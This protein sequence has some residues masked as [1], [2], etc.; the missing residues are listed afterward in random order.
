MAKRTQKVITKFGQKYL[1]TY[2][3]G[4]L[5]STTRMQS[6]KEA[7]KRS[8]ARK[9]YQKNTKTTQKSTTKT[10]A[11]KSTPAKPVTTNK[12]TDRITAGKNKR[13]PL[14]SQT[15]EERTGKVD[16]SKDPRK[17]PKPSTAGKTIKYN[18]YN[19]KY[20]YKGNLKSVTKSS[21]NDMTDRERS[22]RE[23][24]KQIG[25]YTKN[26]DE[27]DLAYKI[28]S[29]KYSDD[30]VRK[31]NENQNNRL[32]GI[33]LKKINDAINVIEANKHKLDGRYVSGAEY[34]KIKKS[35]DEA[36]KVMNDF[37]DFIDIYDRGKKSSLAA[38][39]QSAKD[40]IDSAEEMFKKNN[41]FTDMFKTRHEYY[42]VQEYSK[43]EYKNY[44]RWV[45]KRN[46]LTAEQKQLLAI[47]ENKRT[48]DQKLRL[49]E[50][51][52]AFDIMDKMMVSDPDLIK[53]MTPSQ[54]K[55]YSKTLEKTRKESEKRLATYQQG[56]RQYESEKKRLNTLKG[57]EDVYGYTKYG[58][59]YQDLERS[60][61]NLVEQFRKARSES[62]R[63]AIRAEISKISSYM[64]SEEITSGMTKEEFD[65]EQKFFEELYYEILPPSGSNISYTPEGYMYVDSE[66]GRKA[67][68]DYETLKGMTSDFSKAR[69]EF[70]AQK[71][72]SEYLDKI[73]Y[74][75]DTDVKYSRFTNDATTVNAGVDRKSQR[76][77]VYDVI[78]YGTDIRYGSQERGFDF[79]ILSKL[80]PEERRVYNFIVNK[81]GLDAGFEFI[82]E[83]TPALN[84]RYTESKQIEAYEYGNE[85]PVISLATRGLMAVP[86]ALYDLYGTASDVMNRIAGNDIDIYDRTHL[87][88]NTLSAERQGATESIKNPF[89]QFFYSAADSALNEAVI[90]A[91]TYGLGKA[92]QLGSKGMSAINMVA[93]SGSAFEGK[94]MEYKKAGKS[95]TNAILAGFA[96]AGIEAMTERMPL[97]NIFKAPD[98]LKNVDSKKVWQIM[99][100]AGVSGMEEG[101]EELASYMMGEMY[102]I[103]TNASDMTT[104]YQTYNK[105][106]EDGATK[107]EA[108]ADAF[109]E[110][111]GEAGKNLISGMI[112]GSAL[113]VGSSASNVM[114][115]DNVRKYAEDRFYVDGVTPVTVGATLMDKGNLSSR[116]AA[117]WA[118]HIMDYANGKS[119]SNDV[120]EQI[121][122]NPVLRGVTFA[123]VSANKDSR[124]VKEVKP[125]TVQQT[126][127]VAEPEKESPV[128]QSPVQSKPVDVVPEK[129]IQ[130]TPTEAT[131]QHKAEPKVQEQPKAQ[132]EVKQNTPQPKQTKP[133]QPKPQKMES[134]AD[135]TKVKTSVTGNDG[136]R[137]TDIIN[138]IGSDSIARN[139]KADRP[140]I[141]SANPAGS[142]IEMD[143]PLGVVYVPG[144]NGKTTY[145]AYYSQTQDSRGGQI[146]SV[147]SVDGNVA[148]DAIY[149]M[150]FVD[151][152]G[153]MD[154]VKG[155]GDSRKSKIPKI[156]F[157][158][159]PEIVKQLVNQ[160]FESATPSGIRGQIT[161]T[162]DDIDINN[163]ND[164]SISLFSEVSKYL[165]Q[166]IKNK[167]S[168]SSQM[169]GKAPR[170]IKFGGI[171]GGGNVGRAMNIDEIESASGKYIEVINE[172]MSMDEA[173]RDQILSEITQIP[174]SVEELYSILNA[175]EEVETEAIEPSDEHVS[176]IKYNTEP[177]DEVENVKA[178]ESEVS[179][180]VSEVEGELSNIENRSEE[181]VRD[182]KSEEDEGD[183]SDS[184]DLESDDLE[185]LETADLIM[186]TDTSSVL[187]TMGRNGGRAYSFAIDR[188]L[189]INTLK[190]KG[191]SDAEAREKFNQAFAFMYEA[192][193]RGYDLNKSLKAV[194]L[195][196]A[197]GI[198][199]HAR[200]FFEAGKKDAAQMFRGKTNA[201]LINNFVL[202]NMRA[203][204]E[205]SAR[206]IRALNTLA[207][208]L[209][210]DI[211]FAQK[212]TDKDGNVIDANGKFDAQNH[213]ITINSSSELPFFTVAVHETIHAIRN[214]DTRAYNRIARVVIDVIKSGHPAAMEVLN[215]YAGKHGKDI[216]SGKI[217]MSDINEEIVCHITSSLLTDESFVKELARKNRNLVQRIYDYIIDYIQRKCNELWLTGITPATKNAV[218]MLD[219]DFTKIKSL[220]ETALKS[221]QN[222][223]TDKGKASEVGGEMYAKS[224]VYDYTKSFAEQLDDFDNIPE[225]DSLLVGKTPDVFTKIGFNPLPVTINRTHV[226]YALN[227]TKDID[228]HL[229]IKLLKQLPQALKKP[230][231]IIH[232]QTKQN[233]VVAILK[234]VHNGKN[235]VLPIEIDGF[236]TQNNLRLDSNAIT[237]ILGKTNAIS[238]QLTDALMNEA[239][240]NI[241]VFYWNK[242]EALS[243][244][245]RPGHQLPNRLPQD[246]FVHSI[247]ENGSPVNKRFDNVTYSQQFIRWFGNWIKNPKKASKV[248]NSDGTPKVM[249][250]GG[251]ED[252]RIFDRKKSRASN[253]YGRGFYF[254]DSEA[255]AKQYGDAREYYLN[256]KT[257]LKPNEHNIS[258]EQ[259]RK[260]LEAIAE[261]EDD[262]DI[263]N[264]G[265]TDIDEILNTVYGK[266]DFEVLQDINATAIGDL[267]EAI[268]LF[269]KINNTSYDGI[270][271]PTETVVFRSNQIK[272]VENV[273]TFDEGNDDV[274]Y[275]KF[276]TPEQFHIDDRTF[277]NVGSKSVKAFQFLHPEVKAYYEPIVRELKNDLQN[278]TK[279]ERI[280]LS[281]SE[282]GDYGSNPLWMGTKRFT[283]EAIARI[284]D[285]TGA[286]YDAI[287][288]ALNALLEGDGAENNALSKRIELVIDEMLTDGYTDFEG[289]KIPADKDYVAAKEVL[290]T[291]VSS[292]ALDEAIMNSPD[293]ISTE[294]L[295]AIKSASVKLKE[296]VRQ[297]INKYVEKYGELEKGSRPARDVT[298]PKKT[299]EN[300]YV[301]RNTRTIAEAEAITDENA[302]VLIEEVAND[303]EWTTYERFGDKQAIDAAV[304]EFERIG[305]DAALAKWRAVYDSGKR[306]TK[307]DIADGHLLIKE[308]A[309]RGDTKTFVE[310]ASKVAEMGTMSGQVVQAMFLI[311]RM[312]PAVQI[313]ALESNI[314][315][316]EE[317]INKKH[318]WNDFKFDVPQ[319]LIE[320]YTEAL[321]EEER[322]EKQA[323]KEGREIDKA[324]KKKSDKILERIY[325]HMSR[326]VPKTWVDRITTWRYFA[327]LGNPRTH[328]RNIAGNAVFMP[329]VMTKHIVAA[330][331]ED[332]VG[333]I[334]SVAG[335]NMERTK[336]IRG[337][338]TMGKHWK[339]AGQDA[340][341]I[342]DV[343]RGEA[344]YGEH[345][346]SKIQPKPFKLA[347]WNNKA[348]EFEDWIFLK[349]HYQIALSMYLATNKLNPETMSIAELDKARTYAIR[350]AQKATFREASDLVDALSAIKHKGLRFVID[351]V[352]PFKKT[353]VNILK[354]GVEYSPAGLLWQLKKGLVDLRKGKINASEFIDGLASGTTGTGLLILGVF[355]AAKEAL[356]G[357]S[358]DD[359]KE[360]NEL[361]GIQDYSLTIGGVNF[362]IDW[363]APSAMP[364]FVGCE[365]YKA[366]QTNKEK[367]QPWHYMFSD[368]ADILPAITE[369]LFEM[370][371]LEGLSN[372]VEAGAYEE[373]TAGKL[374]SIAIGI[375]TSYLG[376]F[377]PTLLG[378]I[379]RTADNTQHQTYA[380]KNNAIP[381]IVE[382]FAIQQAKKI[383][384]LSNLLAPAIDKKGQPRTNSEGKN[385]FTRALE[386]FFSPAYINKIKSSTIDEEIQ[387]LYDS[388]GEGARSVIPKS[389]DRYITV[390][391]EKKDLTAKEYT[392]LQSTFGQTY[393]SK[394]KEIIGTDYYDSLSDEN[395]VKLLKKV[396]EYATEKAKGETDSRFRPDSW[397]KIAMETPGVYQYVID[398][399]PKESFGVDD[400]TDAQDKSFRIDRSDIANNILAQYKPDDSDYDFADKFYD[401]LN[402]YSKEVALE[403][404]SDGQ[405]EVDT[406]WMV[407]AKDM[408]SRKQAEFIYAKAL[409][410]GM[411]DDEANEALQ[412]DGFISADVKAHLQDF[413]THFSQTP[414]SVYESGGKGGE[415]L[416]KYNISMDVFVD[417]FNTKDK[418][419]EYKDANGKTVS[420]KKQICEH[421][422]KLNI[423]DAQKSAL[424]RVWYQDK[425]SKGKSTIKEVTWN[426]VW[427]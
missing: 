214:I 382:R 250:R 213:K 32:K 328:I 388:M 164:V 65:R 219:G 88:Q 169:Y 322:E 370:S 107:E 190:S 47:P 188:G 179:E 224:N 218:D 266:G 302:V 149:D 87:R 81:Q 122:D 140:S 86:N 381:D 298:L 239:N 406:K 350:E 58:N 296:D 421:I 158:G 280:M 283:S 271:L 162:M 15:W 357:G 123:V 392:K 101:G 94:L 166:V 67:Y 286:T 105:S 142:T 387:R 300:R 394:L 44:S 414:S 177:T 267:V 344:K 91:T 186:E 238:K 160:I 312:G 36:R 220:Y 203:D 422:G 145:G 408:N 223:Q 141:S 35:I 16:S 90:Y 14:I 323:K 175:P 152:T 278:T 109:L 118:T 276:P 386:N 330:L 129:P 412:K 137:D 355:L 146:A 198:S 409:I 307:Q 204:G 398:T 100:K 57:L 59:T 171:N 393:Y 76:E 21:A 102:S 37:E 228:H 143:K 351:A 103:F 147:N 226:D 292:Q 176:E 227:G 246:G 187:D 112:V 27:Y 115:S 371:M 60:R 348:L 84:K 161:Y 68:E 159:N 191:F 245:Q 284:K 55:E 89:G 135:P 167:L 325:E 410:S 193:R 363:L 379:A 29:G 333:L 172:L 110:T 376:Q 54:R 113:S 252:I 78:N 399:D 56:S 185:N 294:N 334:A 275:S 181:N 277:G 403:K 70:E 243:L 377:V 395:K 311:K 378:Q 127:P 415:N 20:D 28:K 354:R 75:S 39:Y 8:N 25:R 50:I 196:I 38:H 208:M 51:R 304:T 335:R 240:K 301:R 365:L 30:E 297:K 126:T 362:T 336:S 260:F 324:K 73:K 352:L 396:K 293:P 207:K 12:S 201:K 170:Y 40:Y 287:E 211:E 425:N 341:D 95:D 361:L 74:K 397:L 237:S 9:N 19:A 215:I 42:A 383:P 3:D 173:Q 279:G 313:R 359:E 77:A 306:I 225:N 157:K 121:N 229:G 174:Q 165:P 320:E 18:D 134:K 61:D 347:E 17:K 206:T 117:V 217:T 23:S 6:D 373:T 309:A 242:K 367:G 235:V 138:D 52:D 168:F 375:P 263:W 420:V 92:L 413:G 360:I 269:N 274:Y 62:E 411:K 130:P 272:S 11:K 258:K 299:S 282:G 24:A 200:M 97:D 155:N 45:Q 315:N 64:S 163:F 233:R 340:K 405:Y 339:F 222:L 259:V 183:T 120:R 106:L 69:Q 327:M 83:I 180:E 389:L 380:D 262:Y 368:F 13:K 111:I 289:H 343:L 253:L 136:S 31:Y 209:G 318:G 99:K 93:H 264:Y 254:T 416:S 194:D 66:K 234:M 144:V 419:K 417:A 2:E 401:Y 291:G 390:N 255:H 10:T 391:G 154:R 268:E 329:V 256:I 248:V 426:Y 85:N 385:I 4:K 384:R 244:L 303:E 319:E 98:L 131:P 104:F 427:K 156:E 46:E 310:L 72:T 189:I 205:I 290:K 116:E 295:E 349:P 216:I 356:H 124:V 210:V 125:Q 332:G 212:I 79:D 33:D 41:D 285:D 63:S 80:T 195:H 148:F 232:S 7:N 202:R 400:L 366:Y 273:G 270:I 407:A 53:S 353:P 230:I 369:P 247:T 337:I 231:A 308:A 404:N 182:I 192:G 345:K 199:D 423:S 133:V 321:L 184:D 197:K 43:P 261:N 402:S 114:M 221:T 314:K 139:I 326:Q 119:I 372:I 364:L 71:K 34:N 305:Y 338:A 26:K 251:S 96:S 1:A 153:F 241:S 48:E 178:S 236:A 288:A 331:G 132:P 317:E 108:A 128:V 22:V 49:W 82:K 150:D 418:L 249:Y 342:E 374:S 358:D 257:P 424:Y 265:T 316:A 5:I 346:K 281:D 151:E